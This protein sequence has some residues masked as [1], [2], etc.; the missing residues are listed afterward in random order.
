MTDTPRERHRSG[1]SHTHE[2]G[3][4]Y[5]AAEFLDAPVDEDIPEQEISLARRV[6]NWKTIGSAIFALVL[7][8][9]AF[10]TLGVNLASTWELI[11]GANVGFLFLAFLAYYATFPLR[12]FRWRYILSKVGTYVGMR[13][14]TEILFISWFVNCLVPAKL[15]DLYRAYLLKANNGASASKTVG[16]IFI[17]RIADIIVIFFLALAAGYWSFRGAQKPEVDL[18]FLIGF[19]VALFLIALVVVLRFWGDRLARFLPGRFSDLWDRF[20]EGSTGALTVRALPVIGITTVFIWV[21]E[22]TRLYFVIRALDLP[23][24]SLGISSSIFVA[25]VAALMTAM[26]LTPAGIGFVELAIAVALSFYGV[27]QNEA[28]AVALVDRAIS[29][30]TVIVI[31]GIVY[32]LSPKV[33]RA[34]GVAPASTG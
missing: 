28:A 15:G 23:D 7:L 18:V 34:H 19:F 8:A 14:A 2:G 29:I 20:H 5:E 9:L 16:T 21:L 11:V 6:L 25:L 3:S 24:V 22:G 31:G 30:L 33:R 1:E 13:D 32:L 10:R 26:P 12:A 17:E 4:I 27:P